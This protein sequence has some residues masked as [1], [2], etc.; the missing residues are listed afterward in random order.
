MFYTRDD[1]YTAE[2]ECI[3]VRIICY[4]LVVIAMM[5]GR[6]AIL[7]IVPNAAASY[8]LNH[9]S[10]T[11]QAQNIKTVLSHNFSSSLCY[12]KM[13]T[14]RKPTKVKTK[15][16]DIH[17]CLQLMDKDDQSHEYVIQTLQSEDPKWNNLSSSTMT[18]WRNRYPL[19]PKRNRLLL[20]NPDGYRDRKDKYHRLKDALHA[21]VKR[22]EDLNLLRDRETM[23]R[24]ME[25]KSA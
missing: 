8:S 19:G 7:F 13:P 1:E 5:N 3:M 11:T 2:N 25:Q 18:T 24:W 9:D 20:V 15:R 14:V 21:E 6:H 10:E 22:R 4:L 17:Y 16:K 12:T 23:M